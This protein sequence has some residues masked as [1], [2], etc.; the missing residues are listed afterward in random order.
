MS[1]PNRPSLQ[2]PTYSTVLSPAASGLGCQ[3]ANPK[4][5]CSQPNREIAVHSGSN[6]TLL[7]RCIKI[8]VVHLYRSSLHSNEADFQAS[9]GD[10]NYHSYYILTFRD[11]HPGNIFKRLNQGDPV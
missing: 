2:Q 4:Q 8:Q 7:R 10:L 11:L 1:L 9:A 6:Q 5:T 3:Q